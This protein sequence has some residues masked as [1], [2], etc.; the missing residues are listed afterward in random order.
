MRATPSLSL[1]CLPFLALT[2][3]GTAVAQ[4]GSPP[5]GGGGF[6]GVQGQGSVFFSPSGEPFRAAKGDP[7]P[8]MTWFNRVD[9][10]HDGRISH[11]EFVADA[12]AFFA[13]LDI[14]HDNYISSPENTR[15]ENEIAPE[16]TR[17]D[18]RIQQPKIIREESDQSA[19]QGNDLPNGGKYIKQILGAAQYGLIDEPQPIRA[20]DA[21]FDFRISMDEWLNATEERFKLLDRNGDGYITPEELPKTPFQ[22]YLDG[23]KGKKGDAKDGDKSGHKKKGWW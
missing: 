19:D 10:D 12:V 9:T 21:N 17:M 14:N 8:V 3:A 16:I 7:Y 4:D 22:K 15:Y 20:A 18:P 11:D 1:L 13:K 2:L 6:I 23:D 5:Y